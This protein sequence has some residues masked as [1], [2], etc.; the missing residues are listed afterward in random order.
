MRAREHVAVRSVV[1]LVP[2]LID[3]LADGEAAGPA[4]LVRV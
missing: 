1:L 4:W 2:L 3:A